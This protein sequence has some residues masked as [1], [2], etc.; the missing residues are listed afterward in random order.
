MDGKAELQSET[1]NAVDSALRALQEFACTPPRDVPIGDVKMRAE[2][3]ARNLELVRAGSVQ[4]MKDE[5]SGLVASIRRDLEADPQHYVEPI[6]AADIEGEGEVDVLDGHHRTYAFKL[7]KRDSIPAVVL[8]MTRSVALA[9]SLLVNEGDRRMPRTAG[10]RTEAAWQTFGLLT[11][12]GAHGRPSGWSSKRIA[13]VCRVHPN[14]VTKMRKALARI[15]GVSLSEFKRHEINEQTGWI[16]WKAAYS[17]G[18]TYG[19]EPREEFTNMQEKAIEHIRQRIGHDLAR[20]REWA[21]KQE[22]G[23][24]EEAMR[25]IR[26]EADDHDDGTLDTLNLAAMIDWPTGDE[27]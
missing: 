19:E 10:E 17:H 12:R 15:A 13:H 22:R 11:D 6:W 23:L 7:A 16:T 4:A 2:F 25:R 21:Q 3:Q 14:T 18:R 27:F 8:P 5:R 24:F 9:V 26:E 20:I 1:R